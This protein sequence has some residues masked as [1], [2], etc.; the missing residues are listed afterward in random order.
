MGGVGGDQYQLRC[1][2]EYQ[3]RAF[4]DLDEPD[5]KGCIEK[6]SNINADFNQN[7]CLGVSFLQY[8]SG[9]H[10][11]LLAQSALAQS[12]VN[13]LAISAVLVEGGTVGMS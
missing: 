8:T 4:A 5:L 12:S 7:V 10:C 1:S 3:G 9:F 6:C 2:V 11:I 13:V